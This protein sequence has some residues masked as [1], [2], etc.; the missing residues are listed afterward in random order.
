MDK[1]HFN[2]DQ[3]IVIDDITNVIINSDFVV[4]IID[5]QIFPRSGV[6]DDRKYSNSTFDFKQ[7]SVRGL[8]RGDRGS[9]FEL[10][11]PDVDILGSAF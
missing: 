7:S 1:K 8:V 4:S 9:I 3:P 2:I 10:K 11:F 6:I 5:L